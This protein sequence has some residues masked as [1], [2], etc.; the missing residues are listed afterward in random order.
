MT[1][2]FVCEI[3]YAQMKPDSYDA[4]GW[5]GGMDIV[6]DGDREVVIVICTDE[7][8]RKGSGVKHIPMVE[9]QELRFT[10]A[11]TQRDLE[12]PLDWEGL[13]HTLNINLPQKPRK[14]C[15]IDDSYSSNSADMAKDNTQ[16]D[17]HRHALGLNG[18]QVHH[19]SR[20]AIKAGF[21]E[22]LGIS[23]TE[24]AQANLNWIDEVMK[25]WGWKV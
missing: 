14:V 6:C 21:P 10:L 19:S 7:E 20:N 5:M 13:L 4:S 17:E 15:S 12:R 9:Y 25:V 1:A 23:K 24:Y 18:G 22:T 3:P 11:M 8:N 16:E 2:N